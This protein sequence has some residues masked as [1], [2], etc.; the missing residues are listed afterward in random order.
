M[1]IAFVSKNIVETIYFAYL[2]SYLKKRYVILGNKPLKK[3]LIT[4]KSSKANG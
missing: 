1:I 4:K 3:I 2:H